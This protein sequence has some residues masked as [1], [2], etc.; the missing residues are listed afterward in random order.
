MEAKQKT[1]YAKE[2]NDKLTFKEA[3][4]KEFK[5]ISVWS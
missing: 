5:D 1:Y 2:K 4:S 3:E